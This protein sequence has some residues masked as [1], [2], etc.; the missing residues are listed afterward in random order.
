MRVLVDMNLSPAW[1]GA[2]QARGFEAVHWSDIGAHNAPD[3]EIM[4]WARKHGHVVFTHDLDFGALLAATRSTGPSV[5]QLRAQDV[6]PSAIENIV[7]DVLQ[8][9]SEV[10]EVGALVSIDESNA[11]IRILP[12]VRS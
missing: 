11:R 3:L 8:R 5:I 6:L 2:L 4:L 10:L 7:V 9:H 12:L 1:V